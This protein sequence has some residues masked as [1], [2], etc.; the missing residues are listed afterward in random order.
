M[1]IISATEYQGTRIM[2][3]AFSGSLTDRPMGYDTIWDGIF[4]VLN[5]TQKLKGFP[6]KKY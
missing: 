4:L 2:E 1:S 5:M 6:R 3:R